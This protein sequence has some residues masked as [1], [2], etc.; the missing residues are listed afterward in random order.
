MKKEISQRFAVNAREQLKAFI[1]GL[2]GA[3][4]AFLYNLINQPN[5]DL[6]AAFADWHSLLK[7]MISVGGL[8]LIKTFIEGSK[9]ATKE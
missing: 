2:Y 5:F 7:G 3:I 1:L 9:T 4:A 8:Y 6:F